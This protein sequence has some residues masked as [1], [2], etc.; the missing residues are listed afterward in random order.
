MSSCALAVIPVL[1]K[2]GVTNGTIKIS[3]LPN[4]QF[5]TS[6]A[7]LLDKRVDANGDFEDPPV[8]LL[9]GCEYRFEF[10]EITDATNTIST[11]KSEVFQADTSK[12]LTGR[13]RPGLYTGTIPVRVY[14]NGDEVGGFSVEVRSKKLGYLNEYRWMLRDLAD[15]MTEVVMNRFDPAQQQFSTDNERDAKT[16]YQRFA[17]LRAL[18][19]NDDFQGAL[20]EIVRRPHVTWETIH[21]STP[22]GQ[23][24]RAGSYVSMQLSRPGPRVNWN[25][26]PIATIPRRLE[27]QRTEVTIDTVPNRFV[28]FAVTRWRET[29]AHIG[30]VLSQENDS[31]AIIR[32]RNEVQ[33][34]LDYFDALLAEEL[35]REL[36]PLQKFPADNQVLHKREGYRDIYRAYIQFDV[37][38]KLCWEGGEDVY[39]AGKRDVATLY[40]Y[41]TFLQLADVISELCEIPFDFTSLIEVKTDALNVGLKSGKQRVL[42]CVAVRGGRKLEIELWFNRTFAASGQIESSWSRKMR[43]DFSLKISPGKNESAKFEPVFVH[44]DAKYRI[45]QLI[46]VFGEYDEQDS[47]SQNNTTAETGTAGAV[48]SDLLKMHAYRDAIHRSAGAY[49]LYPGNKKEVCREYHELLP[50]LGAFALRPTNDGYASGTTELEQ[51]IEDVI[52]HVASQITQHER[53]RY[54][55]REVYSSEEIETDFISSVPFLRA[56]PADTLVLLGYVKNEDHW[57]WI[58]GNNL[59]NLRADNRRGAIS[60]GAKHL[61]CDFILLSCPAINKTM[62]C[63]IA[64]SPE[65]HTKSQ[66]RQMQYSN[67][68]GPYYCMNIEPIDENDWPST[69]YHKVEQLRLNHNSIVGHPVV[70]TWLELIK[71][72]Y[73]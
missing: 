12:G 30:E 11:D 23:G 24:L 70:V 9:E 66:M 13:V 3:L 61:A 14:S 40:E 47:H 8:Q 65:I 60:L 43:P 15:Q 52:E 39:G 67:P 45:D 32:G 17:F 69:D 20:S 48:R 56:P 63:S 5:N 36:G 35:F 26:G 57:N 59:Y 58:H 18:I 28:K 2:Y 21:E 22:P 71:C 31:Q 27:R 34:L 51:F 55:L 1:D 16:L 72:L 73:V 33:E 68:N 53:G 41:W 54:W 38:A 64:G 49:I 25:G 4:K 19:G 44:F 6:P 37:A 10:L 42:K 62:L 29:V 46:E 50:G 7:P